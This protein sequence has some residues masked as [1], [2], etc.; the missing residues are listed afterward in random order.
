METDMIETTAPAPASAAP[1]PDV[2]L[3]G[4]PI[5]RGLTE[6]ERRQVGEL[7][8]RHT[9]S[10]GETILREGK[11]TRI[12]WIVARGQCEV[13]KTMKHGGEQQLAVLEAGAIFGEMSFFS[14]APHSASVR[15]LTE[16]EVL[17][18]PREEY[19]RIEQAGAKV[20]YKIVLNAGKVLAERLRRMDEWTCELI[21]RPDVAN[22]RDE[23][24]EFQSKLY[25]EWDF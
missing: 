12:L 15:A 5:L 17:L 13:V 16:V 6:S 9:Y 11:A 24:R 18:L 1:T 23:W 8:E 2:S 10:A 25:S 20:A 22:H 7:L 3:N 21:D 4:C 19:D 14:P